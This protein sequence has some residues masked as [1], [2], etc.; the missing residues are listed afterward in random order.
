ML[1]EKV[2]EQVADVIDHLL[3]MVFGQFKDLARQLQET[4]REE[5]DVVKNS[6]CKQI[7]KMLLVEQSF[8][9]QRTGLYERLLDKIGDME[10]QAWQHL[11]HD[12]L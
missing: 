3:M 9:Y 7:K 6:T 12:E 5:L 11:N 1:V 10:K 2:R 4:A 8:T